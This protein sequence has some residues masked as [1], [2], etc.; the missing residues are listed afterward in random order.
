M[1]KILYF[2]TVLPFRKIVKHDMKM[3][4]IYLIMNKIFV[5]NGIIW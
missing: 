3:R 5:Q 1:H 2:Q 4:N